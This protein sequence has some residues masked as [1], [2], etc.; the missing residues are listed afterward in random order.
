[1]EGAG[2]DGGRAVVGIR[3]IQDHRASA[4]LG[5]SATGAGDDAADSQVAGG[6][7]NGGGGAE[8]DIAGAHIEIVR[9]NKS[10][11]AIPVLCIVVGKGESAA[12][13]VVD[14]AAGDGERAGADCRRITDIQGS[15]IQRGAARVGVGGREGEAVGS[16]LC[17]G[18]IARNDTPDGD[19]ARGGIHD[20]GA[21]QGDGS[22]DGLEVCGVVRDRSGHG[23][24]GATAGTGG[25]HIGGQGVGSCS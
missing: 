16:A 10:E 13:G 17:D 1:M 9:A 25:T 3:A 7:G 12:G 22:V 21:G 5:E 24:G 2:I 19:I 20:D 15:S 18:S 8:R 23:E 6:N 11:V 14:R 4:G